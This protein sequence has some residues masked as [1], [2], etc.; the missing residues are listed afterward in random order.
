MAGTYS[1]CVEAAAAC[2]SLSAIFDLTQLHHLITP[3]PSPLHPSIHPSMRPR[4][5]SILISASLHPA[6]PASSWQPCSRSS[7]QKPP[8]RIAWEW[9]GSEGEKS[10]SGLRWRS[11]IR[12]PAVI[13]D[14]T[15]SPQNTQTH[16]YVC[17]S[18][19][20]RTL[21]NTEH[22]PASGSCCLFTHWR[23]RVG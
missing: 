7:N 3:L 10:Q 17:S 12:E 23:T 5:Q 14:V 1:R 22:Q 2:H 4:C 6:N 8:C 13:R 21:V 19:P 20:V 11:G 18:I 16:T 15:P 9:P